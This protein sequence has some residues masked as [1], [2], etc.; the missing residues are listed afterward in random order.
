MTRDYLDPV[1]EVAIPIEQ[2]PYADVGLFGWLSESIYYGKAPLRINTVHLIVANILDPQR[3]I[4]HFKRRPTFDLYV[5][6][7][8]RKGFQPTEK[9]AEAL[10]DFYLETSILPNIIP[11]PKHLFIR[12]VESFTRKLRRGVIIYERRRSIS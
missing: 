2:L 5:F 3:K 9:V 6:G 8:F 1:H 10:A 7:S 11:V 4:R 12:E